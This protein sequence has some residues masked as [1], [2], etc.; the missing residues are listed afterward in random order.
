MALKI[1]TMRCLHNELRFIPDIKLYKLIKDSVYLGRIRERSS[2]AVAKHYQMFSLNVHGEQ[3]L[4]N[5]Q[6][7]AAVWEKTQ[8]RFI[9]ER[10]FLFPPPITL[11]CPI[12]F[13][14]IFSHFF[15]SPLLLFSLPKSY[16]IFF[17]PLFYIFTPTHLGLNLRL[18]INSVH[19]KI[20]AIILHLWLAKHILSFVFTVW[21]VIHFCCL[22]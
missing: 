8:V 15:S 18:F 21:F 20:F 10:F 3:F 11:F 7:L 2:C 12:C 16:L 9:G 1:S 6:G 5:K 22:T 14:T 17:Q 4:E 19:F 13:F